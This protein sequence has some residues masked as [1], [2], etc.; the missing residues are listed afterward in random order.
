[1]K[2][3]SK[4]LNELSVRNSYEYAMGRAFIEYNKGDTWSVSEW[5][6]TKRGMKLS[7]RWRDFGSYK[8]PVYHKKEK[9]EK[10]AEIMEWG[11]KKFGITEWVKTP[12][13]SYMDKSFVVQRN[14]QLTNRYKELHKQ[15]A[16]K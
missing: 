3:T 9:E 13:G 4:I 2:L 11:S 15:D 6:L 12:T 7:L 5:S 16:K 14:A 8:V 1:M 10:L